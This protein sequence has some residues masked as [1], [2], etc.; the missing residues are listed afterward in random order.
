MATIGGGIS[1]RGRCKRIIFSEMSFYN[2]RSY[3]EGGC[4]SIG[5]SSTDTHINNSY[6]INQTGGSI[7]GAISV[8]VRKFHE[9][10]F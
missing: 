1:L 4:I 5:M 3:M 8:K 6:F 2:S 9:K 10:S 7:G